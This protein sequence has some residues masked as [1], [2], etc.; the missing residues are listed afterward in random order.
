MSLKALSN[1]DSSLI[2]Y[3]RWLAKE[4]RNLRFA[5]SDLN[6]SSWI[7]NFVA[8]LVERWRLFLLMAA[9]L[10]DFGYLAGRVLRNHL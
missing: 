10:W 7:G 3:V 6:E 2:V 9:F 5:P 1:M 8:L 4:C